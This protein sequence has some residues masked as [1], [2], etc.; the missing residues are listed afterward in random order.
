MLWTKA[1]FKRFKNNQLVV[2][3]KDNDSIKLVEFLTELEKYGVTWNDNVS[4]NNVDQVD[5]I[6]SYA[7][8]SKTSLCLSCG[9]LKKCFRVLLLRVL[10]RRRLQNR[11][12]YRM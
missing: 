11:N 4:P 12:V 3:F 2:C 1:M 6:L 7:L 9:V 5:Y 10:S 8:S